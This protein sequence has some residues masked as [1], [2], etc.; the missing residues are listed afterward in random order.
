MADERTRIYWCGGH[1]ALIYF[2]IDLCGYTEAWMKICIQRLDGI[3]L[4][5][6]T[7]THTTDQKK[8][9]T[10]IWTSGIIMFFMSPRVVFVQ[11]LHEIIGRVGRCVRC[12]R[13]IH[14]KCCSIVVI[15]YNFPYFDSEI[16]KTIFDRLVYVCVCVHMQNYAYI[17]CNF[18]HRA[19]WKLLFSI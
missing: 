9:T 6:H 18:V 13:I 2:I 5:T 19:K 15:I 3:Y 10:R 12:V 14:N 1:E 8:N 17:V 7:H 11:S 16:M 4:L